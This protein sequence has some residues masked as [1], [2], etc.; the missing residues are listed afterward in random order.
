MLL[1]NSCKSPGVVMYFGKGLGS[2]GYDSKREV[3]IV[4]SHAGD[5]N[6][7]FQGC[8]GKSLLGCRAYIGF[9]LGV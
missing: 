2:T 8:L 7:A 5:H 6:G 1:L 4:T 9:R 3:Y